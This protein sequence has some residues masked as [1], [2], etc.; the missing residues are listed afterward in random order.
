MGLEAG[1]LL[2][3]ELLA[4]HIQ[5]GTDR[6][7]GALA[8]ADSTA[9]DSALLCPAEEGAHGSTVG[10]HPL[11]QYWRGQAESE[12]NCNTHVAQPK[13]LTRSTT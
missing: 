5:P 12:S 9:T 1:L 4:L 7:K 13:T 2:L 10:P 8:L 3:R 6:T 11:L